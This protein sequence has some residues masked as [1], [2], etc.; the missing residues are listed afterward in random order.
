M[1]KNKKSKNKKNKTFDLKNLIFIGLAIYLLHLK[2]YL[3][4]YEACLSTVE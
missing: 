4:R 3:P 1:K 2:P